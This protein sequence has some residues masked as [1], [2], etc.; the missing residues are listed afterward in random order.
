MNKRIETNEYIHTYIYIYIY[1]YIY[2]IVN[3]IYGNEKIKTNDLI[4]KNI[5][6]LK[7]K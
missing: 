3:D 4:Y 2:R 5:I 7:F 1:I 6:Y